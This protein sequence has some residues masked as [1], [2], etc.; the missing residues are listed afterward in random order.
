MTRDWRQLAALIL[1]IGSIIAGSLYFLEMT[2]LLTQS[3]DALNE[4]RPSVLFSTPRFTT[5]L[6][7]F[8]GLGFLSVCLQSWSF[9]RP[10]Q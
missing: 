7:G 6:F 3:T 4:I 9:V 5:L 8:V 10:K 1:Q 2:N